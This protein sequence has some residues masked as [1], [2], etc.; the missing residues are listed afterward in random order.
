MLSIFSAQKTFNDRWIGHP[1]LN[2]AG[3]H[4]LR[5]KTAMAA[6]KFRRA[7][8]LWRRDDAARDLINQGVAVI[9]NFLPP[10]QF[11]AVL[12]EAKH[13]VARAEQNTPAV[14]GTKRGFGKKQMK[15]WGFDRLDG[16][17]LNR[18]INI[19]HETMPACAAITRNKR[20]KALSR[21]VTG[22][23]VLSKYNWVYQTLNGDE[24]RV[25]DI[26]RVMHRDTFFSSMKYWYFLEPVTL[27]DG[28]FEY[29]PTSH[30]LTRERLTWE[31]E[32]AQ[33]GCDAAHGAPS[34]QK[35]ADRAAIGGAFRLEEAELD[36]LNLPKIQ[37]Y[38][39]AANTLVM[40]NTFGFHR[41]GQAKPGTHRLSLYGNQRPQFPFS[42]LGY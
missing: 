14:T 40:A 33:A 26:Q 8:T 42:P 2:K 39:V 28:P 22:V 35:P 19:D 18:F 4:T 34:K 41:R 16:G 15:N 12:E 1:A 30:L 5:L 17:T 27:D 31:A 36:R 7:Q 37:S 21:A 13:S 38:P 3:L 29:V 25:P 23:A 6:T 32:K 20:L 9:P 11:Q 10:D 24:S